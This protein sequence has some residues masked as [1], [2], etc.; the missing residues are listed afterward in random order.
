MANTY[1]DSQLSAAEIEAALEAVDGLIAPANNGKIIAV[2]NGTLV[3][4]SVTEYVDIDLQDKTVTPGAS[5]QVV[6]P[7]SGY[8][9]LSS[10][11]VN[12]DADLVAGNIK[13]DV[14]IF[15]VTGSYEGGGIT[16]IGTKNITQNG[17]YDVTNYASAD[18]NVSGGGGT[19]PSYVDTLFSEIVDS[20]TH[21]D[22]TYTATAAKK[23]VA[24]N[25]ML[26]T[27]GA[28]ISSFFSTISS[29][30]SAEISY[31][32][33]ILNSNSRY[34]FATVK[35]YNLESGDTITFSNGGS[36]NSYAYSCIR[37]VIEIS[38]ISSEIA[39]IGGGF[40][41]TAT[42]N[43][44]LPH[45]NA[46]LNFQF[47]AATN[48]V[49]FRPTITNSNGDTNLILE[50]TYAHLFGLKLYKDT[51]DCTLNISGG[52]TSW[53]ALWFYQILL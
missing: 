15:G 34:L 52:A 24:M 19:V 43:K 39:V 16:P 27:S 38:D 29:N 14:N 46:Y 53:G 37:L 1:Y 30:I 4:K 23:V 28:D 41:D 51:N 13:K 26:L 9:G 42:A 50:N 44:Y 40:T 18:V 21:P 22:S 20:N 5:Q 12:G 2:E 35:E 33:Q 3:A 10:V 25:I 48:R 36:N 8:D 47:A 17:V 7:D 49:N 32:K 6:T 45:L 11:T 31:E